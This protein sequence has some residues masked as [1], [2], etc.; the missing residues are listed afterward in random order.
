MTV[1]NLRWRPGAWRA[2]FYVGKDPIT[3]RKVRKAVT[4]REPNTKAGRR[5][6]EVEAARIFSELNPDQPSDFPTVAELAERWFEVRS[7]EWSPT[8][9]SNYRSFLD[10]IIL[11]SLGHHQ[12]DELTVYQI[13]VFYS[14]VM[15][16]GG[17]NGRPLSPTSVRRVHGVLRAMLEQARR[18]GM[19][20][21]NPCVDATL[22]KQRPVDNRVPTPD[23]VR[24]IL[25]ACDTT[26][27][28]ALLRTAAV[29]GM[30]RGELAG[31][32]WDDIDRTTLLVRRSV[33]DPGGEIVVKSTKSGHA[34]S[35]SVDPSTVELL[36]RHRAEV[37]MRAAE[38]GLGVGEWVWSTDVA[39]REPV[40]PD[41]LSHVSTRIRKRAG[42]TGV[43]L[44]DLRGFAVTHSLAVANPRQ[45]ADRVGHRSTATSLDIYAQSVDE[46]DQTIATH[47]CGL[48]D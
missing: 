8:T 14:R 41:F 46:L 20:R 2:Q 12:V 48:L 32:Q 38:E 18:W 33:V 42:L 24:R 36:E 6:A 31:L 7:P 21:W 11:P 34:R 1:G 30:R 25:E 22:P 17:V 15:K 37:Q 40:R 45:V 39:H 19:I 10:R 27:E 44:H 5:A 16:A 4:I 47:L 43:R 13:D 23:E 28:L 35:T 3:G 9:V 26:W 29:T